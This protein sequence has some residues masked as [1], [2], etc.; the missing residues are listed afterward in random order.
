[1]RLS[2]VDPLGQGRGESPA[3]LPALHDPFRNRTMPR[4]PVPAA[5]PAGVGPTYAREDTRNVGLRLG[6]DRQ[7]HVT[8]DMPVPASLWRYVCR[9][10]GGLLK[11]SEVCCSLSGGTVCMI[12]SGDVPPRRDTDARDQPHYNAV[13]R[14]TRGRR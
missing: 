7:G 3:P 2:R 10:L 6:S 4:P 11:N 12:R 13:N 8:R 1:M 9:F 14:R 5:K